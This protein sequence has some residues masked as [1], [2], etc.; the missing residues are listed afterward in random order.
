MY[1][2]AETQDSRIAHYSFGRSI[3]QFGMTVFSTTDARQGKKIF[4]NDPD[5]VKEIPL[6]TQSDV[7]QEHI[8]NNPKGIVAA[9][10]D[11]VREFKS[12]WT[13]INAPGFMAD[14]KVDGTRQHNFAILNFT[15]KVILIGGTGYTGEI[16]KGIFS[17]LNFTLPYQENV[18][19]MH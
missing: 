15:K 3:T 19:S 16:K 14:P 17:A 1:Q 8:D 5:P 12:E 6:I 10:E 7:V 4:G 2:F 18:L 9:H 11:E 13:I